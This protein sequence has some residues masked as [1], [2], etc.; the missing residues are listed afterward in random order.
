MFFTRLAVRMRARHAVPCLLAVVGLAG[1]FNAQAR[2]SISGSPSGSDTVGT[3]YTFAPKATDTRPRTLYFQISNKPAWASFST[4][5][6]K[7]TG[8][9]SASNVGTF[10]NIT[11]KVSDGR[12]QATLTPFSIAV[13]ASAGTPKPG[14]GTATVTWAPPTQNSDGTAL[15]N[16]AGYK[17]DYG[18]SSGALTKTVQVASAGT[19]SYTVNNLASGTWYFAVQSYTNSGS[20]SALS[21]VTSKTIP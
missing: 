17:I 15:T 18:T 10:S 20:Q 5:T 8:T 11:I 14:S 2:V 21:N 7:L 4:S 19:S 13:I 12:T 1:S 16:L 3:L 9:P 6:G